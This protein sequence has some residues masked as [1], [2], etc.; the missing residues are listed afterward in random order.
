MRITMIG[1]SSV[2]IETVGKKIL[3]D[4]FWNRWGNPAYARI[5][6]P[7]MTHEELSGVDCVLVSHAH[8]DHT[9]GKFFRLIGDAPVKAPWLAC[10]WLKLMGARNLTGMW[11]GQSFKLG[12]ITITAVRAIHVAVTVGYV[13]QS[14]GKLLYFAGDT[15]YSTFMQKLG[16]QFH[17]DAALMPVT[18]YRIPMTMGER[19]AVKAVRALKP[20][21]VIPIHLGIRPRSLLLE[22]RQTPEHFATRLKVDGSVAKVVILREGESFGV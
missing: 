15:Y 12:E 7:A 18:T 22:T 3:T 20:A 11:A 17:L 16:Q 14:E 10:G 8:W 5:G 1:H 19:S 9:D 6:M 21:V 13:I 2:L 4:P